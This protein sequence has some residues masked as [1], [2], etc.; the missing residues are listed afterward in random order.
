MNHIKNVLRCKIGE[1]IEI[2]NL[3]KNEKYIVEIA[4]FFDTSIL[5]EIIDVME[6]VSEPEVQIT[7]VQALPK[8]DKMELIIQKAT[9]LGVKRI[10]P[11]DMKRCVVKLEGKA[12]AKKIERWTS[13]AEAAAKQCKRRCITEITTIYDLKNI[14]QI[15]DANDLAIVLY[16]NET[17]LGLKDVLNE[18]KYRNLQQELRLA[19][20]SNNYSNLPESKPAT[21]NLK[22]AVIIGPEGGV[23]EKEIEEFKK[24]GV[25]SVSLG[26]RIL[27]TETVSIAIASVMLYEL[28][29]FGEV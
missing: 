12:I 25:R 7:I 13:I 27:R 18:L 26:K 22:I 21:D 1:R 15:I 14:H 20:S 5:C 9:E 10:V 6:D 29:E 4:S 2:S 24:M 3:D 11:L 23:E 8:M 28:D 17:E 19:A 16:E